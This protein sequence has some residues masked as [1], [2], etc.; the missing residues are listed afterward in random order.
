MINTLV[1][2]FDGTL[3]D[4][5]RIKRQGFLIFAR[6]DEGGEVRM[7]RILEKVSGDRSSILSAY[8]QER[9]GRAHRDN[10]FSNALKSYN[11]M[12]D[13]AVVNAPELFGASEFLAAMRIQGFKLVLSSATPEK[14]LLDIVSRRG[15]L[16]RFDLVSG[17][18]REKIDTLKSLISSDTSSAQLAVVGDG[19]DDKKSAEQIGCHFFPVGEARGINTSEKIYT[20]P[21]IFNLLSSEMKMRV[22]THA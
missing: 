17:S 19:E 3:V 10:E 7:K 11:E 1:L 8:L 6:A 5:N 12:V 13:E 21:E 20:L 16:D 18:P 2:D 9:D 14:N 15:W 22:R 4:S